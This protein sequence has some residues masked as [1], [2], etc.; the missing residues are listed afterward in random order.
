MLTPSEYAAHDALGLMDLLRRGEVTAHELH[1]CALAAIEALNP[2]LNFLVSRAED[3]AALALASLRPDAPFAGLPFLVK[4]GVGMKGQPAVLASRLAPDL[5]ANTDGELVVRLRRAGVV[6]LG[7]T[8][9]PEFGN[10]PTTEPLLHGPV[11]NPWNPEHM[12]GGSSGGASA[13]VAAGVVPVAQSSDGGGSIRT[14]AHCCGVFGLKPTRGR[15][16]QG[17]KSFGGIFGLGTPHVTTRSVRDCAAF[18]DELLGDEPGA[19]Y[20]IGRPARPF[21]G[22][23]GAGPGRLRIAF[24]TTSPSGVPI[25]EDCRTATE[26]AARLCADLG[27]DV[28]EA[29]PPYDWERFRAAFVDVWCANFPHAVAALEAATGRKA[30]PDTLETANLATLAHGRALTMEQLGRSAM[31]LFQLARDVEAFFQ[32]WDVLVSPVNL[33]PAPRLGV[34]DANGTH[35]SMREWFD[36]AIGHFAA[37]VPI[38]NATGQPAMSVPLGMSRNG[39]PVGVQFAARVGDEATLFRLAAQLESARPWHDR[40]PPLHAAYIRG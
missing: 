30:G 23:V 11:R 33:T 37:F 7:S 10:A 39:L 13:A 4:E 18:L 16:P 38:F 6:I 19:L 17:P 27:H 5:L 31:Q 9:A 21:L 24:S 40:R 32:D 12:A 8:T 25:D 2:R 22:E 29:A 1:A 20:R 3:D 35:Q 28:A 36:A 15:T 26:D 34:I 14:P